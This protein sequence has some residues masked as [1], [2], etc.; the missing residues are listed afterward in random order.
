MQEF[1]IDIYQC[2]RRPGTKLT[3]NP[4]FTIFAFL[5]YSGYPDGF[6]R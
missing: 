5:N 4:I 3:I 2:Y 6:G 1:E